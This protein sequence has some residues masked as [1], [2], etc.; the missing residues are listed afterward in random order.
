MEEGD[1][2]RRVVAAPLRADG[3]LLPL[4]RMRMTATVAAAIAGYL[5]LIALQLTLLSPPYREAAAA[6]L[7]LGQL[8]SVGDPGTCGQTVCLLGSSCAAGMGGSCL[9]PLTPPTP[10][11]APPPAPLVA[12]AP[13][14]AP[15]PSQPAPVRPAPVTRV[16]RH[17]TVMPAAPP[18]AA[19]PATVEV[20][21]VVRAA[22][23]APLDHTPPLTGGGVPAPALV[24][25]PGPATPAPAETAW[26]LYALFAAVDLAAA[27]ALV[28][29]IRR[30]AAAQSR[31]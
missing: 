11:S 23:A 3:A 4:R 24:A 16:P 20:V 26:W 14:A 29:L 6:P 28:L 10:A 18:P 2:M 27:V 19:P 31:G 17:V 1:E 22:P 7:R 15:P 12:P 21:P 25:A 30:T 8:L 9:L 5:A 13:A